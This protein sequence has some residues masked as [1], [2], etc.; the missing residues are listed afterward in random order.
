[1]I[2]DLLREGSE[3]QSTQ[4]LRNIQAASSIDDFVESFSVA[5]LLLNHALLPSSKP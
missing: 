1:M 2:L 3:T 4:L 5:N